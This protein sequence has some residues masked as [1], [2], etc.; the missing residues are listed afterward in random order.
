MSWQC[1]AAR[2]GDRCVDCTS[3]L[4][5]LL[6]SRFHARSA[7]LD[8]VFVPDTKADPHGTGSRFQLVGVTGDSIQTD[9]VDVGFPVLTTTNELYVIGTTNSRPVLLYVFPFLPR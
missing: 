5:P 9:I 2:E 6:T 1:P 7:V 3:D 4:H 8:Q